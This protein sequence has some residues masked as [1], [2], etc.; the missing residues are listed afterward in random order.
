MKGLIFTELLEMVE[1]K[2]GLETLEY[3]ID[4]SNLKSNGVYTSIGNYDYLELKSL[5]QNLSE[6]TDIPLDDLLKV[7]GNFFF[8]NATKNSA[9]NV[10]DKFPNSISLLSLIGKFIK[11]DSQKLYPDAI[12]P[13]LDVVERTKNK[14]ILH[15]A[16]PHCLHAFLYGFMEKTFEYYKE[17]AKISYELLKQDGS[18]VRFQIESC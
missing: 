4:K 3:I 10:L 16:S 12:T 15:Y 9:D 5:L 18:E 17:K 7:Y 6:T 1:T 2:Y 14:L 11:T 8:E 13:R